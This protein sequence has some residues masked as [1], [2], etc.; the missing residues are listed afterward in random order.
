[1]PLW[2]ESAENG[3]SS[4][5]R[6][7]LAGLWRDLRTLD[8][9]VSELDRE[10]TSIAQ[11]DPAAQR[12][13]QLRAVGPIVASALVAAVG[14]ARHFANARQMA[15]SLGLTPKQHSSGGKQRLLGISK[16]GDCYVRSVL[17]STALER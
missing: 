14:D 2:L 1:M 13:Q 16:R 12:L 10:I 8:D 5:F 4:R 15:A 17:S 3:L 11:S 9:R 6:R 7:L